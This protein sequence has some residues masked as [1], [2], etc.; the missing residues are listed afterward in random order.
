MVAVA[1]AV[2]GEWGILA[3]PDC[4][5]GFRVRLDLH[6][7]LLSLKVLSLWNW[8]EVEDRQPGGGWRPLGD[9]THPR[10]RCLPLCS[11]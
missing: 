3:T 9:F 8:V 7:V 10:L 11:S 6:G 1:P 2:A 5:A 4:A